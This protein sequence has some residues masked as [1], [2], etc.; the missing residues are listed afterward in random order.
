MLVAASS[1]THEERE[2]FGP[3]E[4]A[5][6]RTIRRSQVRF[7]EIRSNPPAQVRL[8][9]LPGP[10]HR[11]HVARNDVTIAE[12]KAYAQPDVLV[13]LGS[14]RRIPPIGTPPPSARSAPT[15][16]RPVPTSAVRTP[17]RSESTSHPDS[18]VDLAAPHFRSPLARPA[19][20]G[21]R[22][23][24]PDRRPGWAANTLPFGAPAVNGR[25]R[26]VILPNSI[27][28]LIPKAVKL[29]PNVP[30]VFLRPEDAAALRL[31]RSPPV[32]RGAP[33]RRRRWPGRWLSVCAPRRRR[34]SE[35]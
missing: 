24:Q 16:H 13:K 32:L 22:A 10:E 29:N 25:T 4:G 5:S 31:P 14:L 15:A 21:R 2:W 11:R 8:A 26:S 7:A 27:L 23:H 17:N 18:S 20:P 19:I 30:S 33:P 1:W 9:S 28:T 3:S 6:S 35:Q 12:A 34:G